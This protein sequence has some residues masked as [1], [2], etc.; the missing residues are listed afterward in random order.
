LYGHTDPN[1]EIV[2]FAQA[3]ARKIQLNTP[4]D[5]VRQLA[6]TRHNPPLVTVAVRR[7][8]SVEAI[9]FVIGSG[10][11]EVDA[12]I[13]RIVQSHQPFSPFN[14]ELAREVDVLEIRRTWSFSSVVVLQ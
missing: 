12:A 7:D 8:G 4:P 14:A 11:P 2:A 1:P 6:Q 5:L 9:T 3:W 13:R 10:S